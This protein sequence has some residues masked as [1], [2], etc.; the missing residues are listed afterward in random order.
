MPNPPTP[1]RP[2]IFNADLC[3]GCNRCVEVCMT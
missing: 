3:T 1:G 2:V